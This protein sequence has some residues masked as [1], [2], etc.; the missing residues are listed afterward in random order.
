MASIETN[1]D[2]TLTIQDIKIM[3]FKTGTIERLGKLQNGG[4]SYRRIVHNIDNVF[5]K[6]ILE[7][8]DKNKH[9][10]N[11]NL[12]LMS[13][14]VKSIFLNV[15][16][17]CQYDV[18]EYV[19]NVMDWYFKGLAFKYNLIKKQPNLP[20]F[21]IPEIIDLSKQLATNSKQ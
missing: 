5:T 7:M 19:H 18:I 8:N 11:R 4:I 10:G 14:A 13:T 20:D 17:T 9:L 15:N 12:E 2:A 3:K 16:I 1:D 21:T 6:Y